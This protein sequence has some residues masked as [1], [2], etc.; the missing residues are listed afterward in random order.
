MLRMLD[1]DRAN[2]DA[3]ERLLE[4]GD[5]AYVANSFQSRYVPPYESDVERLS[6]L[7][8]QELIR[9]LAGGLR[10]WKPTPNVF[11]LAEKADLAGRS[12]VCTGPSNAPIAS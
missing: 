5:D 6:R 2:R 4:G 3:L 9:C 8:E 10:S 11:S 7:W 12:P 1:P